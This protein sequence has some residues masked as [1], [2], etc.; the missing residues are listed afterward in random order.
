MKDRERWRNRS[1]CNPT[2]IAFSC[3]CDCPRTF[4][5]VNFNYVCPTNFV[6]KCGSKCAFVPEPAFCILYSDACTC[7]MSN[8]LIISF[9]HLG[10]HYLF[11]MRSQQHKE[12]E[13]GP[14]R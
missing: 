3:S 2:L 10:S 9:L 7:L 5:N 1:N 11:S 4:V 14:P 13:K 8:Y 12:D 6:R